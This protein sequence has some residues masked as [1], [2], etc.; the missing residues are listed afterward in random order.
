MKLLLHIFLLLPPTLWSQENYEETL[1]KIYKDCIDIN[2]KYVYVNTY[3]PISFFRGYVNPANRPWCIDCRPPKDST[4]LDKFVIMVPQ[5]IIDSL[6]KL[7]EI[8]ENDADAEEV[9]LTPT[10]WNGKNL[11]SNIK[12]KDD[13][14][15]LTKIKYPWGVAEEKK[16]GDKKT[17]KKYLEFDKRYLARPLY[18]RSFYTFSKPLIFYSNQDKYLIIQVEHNA[19]DY[20][21]RKTFLFKYDKSTWV[22]LGT[23]NVDWLY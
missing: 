6:Y 21:K 9:I 16:W 2:F 4:L 20:Y 14:Y 22:K 1:N 11:A 5:S 17:L 10:K 19:F 15:E 8:T 23:I 18:K 3:S 12:L 7:E 13:P